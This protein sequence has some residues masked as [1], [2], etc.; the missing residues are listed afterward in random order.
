LLAPFLY[1]LTLSYT[2]ACAGE[3]E[4]TYTTYEDIKASTLEGHDMEL[5]VFPAS[6]SVISGEPAA[7]GTV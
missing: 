6:C 2:A 3:N 5:V 7:P 4:N 1:N